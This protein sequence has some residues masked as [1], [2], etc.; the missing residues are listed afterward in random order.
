MAKDRLS[1]T[2]AL[3]LSLSTNQNALFTL[4]YYT[5]HYLFIVLLLKHSLCKCFAYKYM[6]FHAPIE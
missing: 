5:F 2:R 3:P 6:H 4:N 1:K